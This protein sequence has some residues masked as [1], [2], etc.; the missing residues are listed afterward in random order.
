[1]PPNFSKN[2]RENIQKIEKAFFEVHPEVEPYYNIINLI[3]D[4]P[5]SAVMPHQGCFL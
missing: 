4:F 2:E 3:K 1:M 5:S